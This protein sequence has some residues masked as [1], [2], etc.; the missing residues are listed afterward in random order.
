MKQNI[1]DFTLR[2]IILAFVWTLGTTFVQM[3]KCPQLTQTQLIINIPN[4][5]HMDFKVCD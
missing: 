2:I 4:S 3:F 1:A 5:V